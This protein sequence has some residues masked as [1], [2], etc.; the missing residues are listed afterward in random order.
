MMKKMGRAPRKMT[1][2]RV[3]MIW[4]ICSSRRSR[5]V[6]VRVVFD[7]FY[8]RRSY[9]GYLMWTL[10]PSVASAGHKEVKTR[11]KE[12]TKKRSTGWKRGLRRAMVKQGERRGAGGA[13][14]FGF[15]V[16][17]GR[18]GGNE[19][20]IRRRRTRRRSVYACIE[21]RRGQRMLE[22]RRRREGRSVA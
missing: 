21:E 18:P 20:Q 12:T 19:R 8:G 7:G 22:R 2:R 3:G 5:S 10:R 1:E 11:L 4:T 14:W 6:N 13:V 17:R 16:S 9:G 15:N